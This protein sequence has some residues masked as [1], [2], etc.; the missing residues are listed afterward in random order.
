MLVVLRNKLSEDVD[1]FA[2]V[3]SKV[4]AVVH[5]V[6]NLRDDGKRVRLHG[7]FSKVCAAE[8][9]SLQFNI[10]GCHHS[11]RIKDVLTTSFILLA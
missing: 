7:A 4:S 5:C 3:A 6:S 9:A 2:D 1:E 8:M 10:I 11:S